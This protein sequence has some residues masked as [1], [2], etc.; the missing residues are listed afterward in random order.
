MLNV[1][2]P[3]IVDG[4]LAFTFKSKAFC[5]A[6]EIG[7]F[8]S[9]VLSTLPKP[10]SDFV[11]SRLDTVTDFD[12]NVGVSLKVTELLKVAGLSNVAVPLNRMAPVNVGLFAASFVSNAA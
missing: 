1:S 4:E 11:I 10:T 2:T 12:G 3:V 6:T 5:V 7:L 8:S 9:E